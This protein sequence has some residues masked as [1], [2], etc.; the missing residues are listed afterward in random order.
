MTFR[1]RQRRNDITIGISL[2]VVALRDSPSYGRSV[3]KFLLFA[4]NSNLENFLDALTI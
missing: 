4:K 1:W 3:G 2:R